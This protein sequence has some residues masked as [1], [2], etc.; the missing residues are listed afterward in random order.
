MKIKASLEAL[1]SKRDIYGNCYWA[2]RYMDHESGK[3]VVGTISG[4]EGNIHAAI[5]PFG[6]EAPEVHY[7]VAELPI[8]E[9]NRLTKPWAYAGCPPKDIATYIKD[10]LEH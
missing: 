2:F 4:G 7:T 9:F 5:Y 3:Q 6:L 8:R 10:M 1:Y